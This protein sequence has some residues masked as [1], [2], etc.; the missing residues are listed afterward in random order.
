MAQSPCNRHCT[1]SADDL[2]VGCFRSL[3][4]I[5]KWRSLSESEQQQVL[6]RCQKR[7]NEHLERFLHSSSQ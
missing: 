6:K 3:E 4:E 7:K 5:L 1:L 2:C